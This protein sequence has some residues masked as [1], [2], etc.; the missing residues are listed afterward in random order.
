[1]QVEDVV[2][3]LWPPNSK[4]GRES[5]A[6]TGGQPSVCSRVAC[7][8]RTQNGPR[9]PHDATKEEGNG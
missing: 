6:D 2:C 4:R 9:R 7:A 1:M 8:A 5:R 3:R